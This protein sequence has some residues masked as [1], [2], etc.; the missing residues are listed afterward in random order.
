MVPQ[1]VLPPGLEAPQPPARPVVIDNIEG[2]PGLGQFWDAQAEWS[3]ATFGKDGERGPKGALKHL[4]M[5]VLVELLG[6]DK[7]K[8]KAFLDA[9]TAGV[10]PSRD[11]YEYVDSQLLL[12]SAARRAGHSFRGLVEACWIKLG[13]NKRRKW[14][15][16]A[17]GEPSEHVR[18]EELHV[19]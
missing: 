14:Q 12:F 2:V 6:I 1:L 4:A 17:P 10:E 9:E 3:Q 18:D 8:A 13:I 7:A 15:R 19:K 5:E 16:A 11:L